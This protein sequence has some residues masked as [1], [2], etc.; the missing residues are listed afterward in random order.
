MRILGIGC[1]AVLI[2]FCLAACILWLA[3]W[4]TKLD[5][6][7]KAACVGVFLGSLF[8]ALFSGVMLLGALLFG[9]LLSPASSQLIGGL[10]YVL[11]IF[12]SAFGV[13][14]AYGASYARALGTYVLY[15]VFTA[16]GSALV[17]GVTVVGLGLAVGGSASEGS[18]G[19]GSERAK[20][21]L[22]QFTEEVMEQ[23]TAERIEE[24][25]SEMTGSEGE[26][27]VEPTYEI[28]TH[29][30][31]RAGALLNRELTVKLTDSDDFRGI[32]TEVGSDTL[33][34][35]QNLNGGTMSVPIRKSRVKG[36]EERVRVSPE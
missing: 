4:V 5:G 11:S 3:A 28:V 25:L 24:A 36:F 20:A 10:A 7:F 12:V 2:G 13:K 31:T 32:L 19:S 14:I 23:P 16:I 15:L 22:E 18:G 8:G 35:R 21:L 33:T 27:S 6:K 26:E 34:F 9:A 17:L 29:P 30:V 1:S